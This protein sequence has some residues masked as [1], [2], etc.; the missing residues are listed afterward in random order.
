MAPADCMLTDAG[1]VGDGAPSWAP[2]GFAFMTTTATAIT[3]TSETANSS[4][5]TMLFTFFIFTWY[6]VS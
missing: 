5:V 2:V 6:S 3:A 4:E 1:G